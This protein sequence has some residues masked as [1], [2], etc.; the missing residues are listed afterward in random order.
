MIK[1]ST[2]FIKLAVVLTFLHIYHTSQVYLNHTKV[3]IDPMTVSTGPHQIPRSP[4]SN[5]KAKCK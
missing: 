5:L 1:G 4:Q 3:I 2:L